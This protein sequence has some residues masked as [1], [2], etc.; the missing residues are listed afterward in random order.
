MDNTLSPDLGKRESNFNDL[1]Q[2]KRNE[3]FNSVNKHRRGSRYPDKNLV[4]TFSD[5]GTV[6]S[7][8]SEN[9][10]KMYEPL[11]N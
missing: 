1:L 9:K 6:H 7:K 11:D 8:D 2:F 4:A 5:R 10:T 3:S